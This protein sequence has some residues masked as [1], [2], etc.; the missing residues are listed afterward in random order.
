M[1]KILVITA[2]LGNRSTL[3]RTIDSVRMIGGEY[4]KHVIVAPQKQIPSIKEKYGNIECLA[5]LE[6]KKGIYAALN[7][8]FNTYGHDYEYMTFINDDDYWLPDFKILI[9]A[10]INCDLDLVYARTKYVD[11]NG[12]YL[13]E[14]TCSD[15]FDDFIALLNS[16]IVL[17]TQQAT[18]I[19]SKWFFKLNG[20]DES[21]KI[22]ADSKFWALLSL[23][24][25]KFKYFNCCCAAYTIQAGQLSS[26]RDT[27][28]KE[29]IRMMMELPQIPF[30]QIKLA[31]IRF[32]LT[33][34]NIYVK[35][36]LQ[37]RC[38]LNPFVEDRGKN[39]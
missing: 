21:C 38:V 15:R 36:M 12:K 22:V 17:F 32:R 8:G 30:Y 23:E 28:A 16:K 18:I 3:Q 19:R 2:T 25:I 27:Q 1:K 29:R 20:F 37:R 26:D 39:Q 9:D 33:N 14:Q 10:I 6:G 7:H 13:S 5:E 35:R 31:K 34:I 24:V 4:V 11:K